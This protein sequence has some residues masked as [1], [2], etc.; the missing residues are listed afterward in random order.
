MRIVDLVDYFR[1][2]GPV[3]NAIAS[4][5]LLLSVAQGT[6][7][8]SLAVSQH[9]SVVSPTATIIGLESSSDEPITLNARSRTGAA[10]MLDG[11]SPT[12]NPTP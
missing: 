9:L 1:A 8:F 3:G 12:G 7:V 11:T 5:P 10:P 2:T 6:C 4:F